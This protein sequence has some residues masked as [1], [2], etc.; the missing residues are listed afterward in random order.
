MT[1]YILANNRMA[2]LKGRIKKEM[3]SI[4]TNKELTN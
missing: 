3:I 1:S 2:R 4:T